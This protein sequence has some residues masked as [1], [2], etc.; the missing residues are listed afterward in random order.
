MQIKK[1]LIGLIVGFGLI[2][3]G[4]S[5][6]AIIVTF[7]LYEDYLE[8]ISKFYK[9]KVIKKNMFFILGVGAGVLSTMFLV[10]KMFS[11]NIILLN[12]IF[13]GIMSNTVYQKLFISNLKYKKF[14]LGN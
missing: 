6:T 7:N 10:K 8:L 3:P 1:F 11:N 14:I 13:L 2:I 12:G 4:V 5:F 9:F